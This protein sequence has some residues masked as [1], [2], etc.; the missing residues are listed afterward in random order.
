MRF[1]S[2]LS[3]IIILMVAQPAMGNPLIEALERSKRVDLSHP[4]DDKTLFWPTSPIKFDHK[5]LAFGP[6]GNGYFYSAYTLALPEHGG[7]HLDAPIH[8]YEG[9]KTVGDIPLSDL[10]APAIVIDVTT[11]SA[12]NRDYRLTV[13]D[14]L[15]FEA[16]HGTIPQGSAVLLRTGWSKFWPDAKAY[17]GDD[18]PGDASKLSFPSF[19][20]EA[21]KV[22]V[23]RG[24]KM[25]GIDTASTDYGKTKD[26]PVHVVIAAAGISALENLTNLDAL[27]QTG[28]YVMAMPL[29]VQEGSGAPARVIAL[30][31]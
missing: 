14:V 11:Q 4:F 12:E 3:F 24:I 19:G 17:M 28:A 6:S 16:A 22:L 27:P 7:T 8:F 29:K 13:A 10:M 1:F 20:A 26:F 31:P 23:G 15:A 21:M 9:G 2:F 5:E 18:T 30:L 25:V